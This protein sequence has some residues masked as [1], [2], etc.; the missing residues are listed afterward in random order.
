MSKAI[1]KND[2]A[3]RLLLELGEKDGAMC[4]EYL[5]SGKH[6]LAADTAARFY[7][8]Y[9]NGSDIKEI[10]RLN[11]A[12]PIEAIMIAKVKYKW[13]ESRESY[14]MELQSKIR[15][16]VVKT[17]LETVSFMT[18]MMS[19][20]YKLHGDKIKKFL[21]TGNPEDAKGALGIDTLHGLV[22]LSETL[23]KITGQGQSNSKS[24]PQSVV[25]I[26]MQA[27]SIVSKNR[28]ESE[29]D[30]V[31]LSEEAIDKILEIAY[32]DTKK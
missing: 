27:P 18:D 5:N 15:D 23:Q 2:L 6:L 32:Q 9:L 28:G 22:K 12:Y 10:H 7:E 30:G 3:D 31:Q 19:A 17:Q 13:D 16:K 20:T 4:I 14:F 11:K 8:L 26:S 25:S 1:E 24:A 21:Q 29:D